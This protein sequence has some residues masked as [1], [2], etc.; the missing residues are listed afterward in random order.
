MTNYKPSMGKF[1]AYLK[2]ILKSPPRIVVKAVLRRLE[3]AANRI[4]ERAKD[5][6]F[7]SYTGT[8]PQGELFRY[9][10][11][12]PALLRESD[13]EWVR[14]LTDRYL[15]HRF[16]LLGSGWVSVSHGASCRGVEGNR[17][18]ESE[19]VKA[20]PEGRWLKTK[21]NKADRIESARRWRTV[22]ED[23]SPIDWHLDFKSGYRW[24][25]DIWYQ[26]VPYAHEPGVDIKV[27]WEL[28]RMQHLPQLAWAY[29]FAAEG[30][31]GF[32]DADVY[33][34]QFR[35]QV[36]DFT[37]TNPPRFGVNWRC[38]MDVGIRVANQLLAYDLFQAFGAAFDADFK[39]VFR[40]SVYEHGL[41]IIGNLEW[42]EQ[43]RGNHYLADIV[44]LLFVA[45]YLPRTEETD[46][47]LAFAVQELVKEA[48]SQFNE[49]GSNFEGST[50]Y[51]RLSSEMMIF[52]AAL[53]LGLP[54]E[55]Y[56]A[57]KHCNH[58][59]LRVRP[60][61]NAGPTPLYPIPGSDRPA[62]FP[63]RYFE[64]LEK[65]AEFTMDITRPDGNIPQVGDNDAGRFFKLAPDIR[66]VTAEKTVSGYK[67]PPD[68]FAP[69]ETEEYPIENLNDHRRMVGAVNGLFERPDF[70][71]FAG[72]RCIDGKVAAMLSRNARVSSYKRNRTA[73]SK[74][75]DE[76]S[77]ANTQPSLKLSAYPEFGLYVYHSGRFYWAVRCGP[78]GQRGNGGHSH[79]DQLSFELAV[80]DEPVFIDPGT[81]LYTPVPN[82]RNRFRSTAMH[83]TLAIPGIEQNPWNPGTY[84]LF[85][86][87]ADNTK[88]EAK[89]VRPN[90]FCGE[91]HGY[92]VTHRRTMEYKEGS[93]FVTDELDDERDAKLFFHLAPGLKA[94]VSDENRSVMIK[95]EDTLVLLSADTGSWET[96]RNDYSPSYGR[97]EP[98]VTVALKW[99]GRKAAW[100]VR[101]T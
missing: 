49:D 98:N 77:N 72:S 15:A 28:A 69:S 88:A 66:F 94:E 40:R 6:F 11:N 30:R 46:A 91:H 87:I 4:R 7:T 89:T 61:L 76:D 99:S 50:S 53:A 74:A 27:P 33:R 92:G 96:F 21:I 8:R 25:E 9:I 64:Q 95:K 20:D 36:L 37:A 86:V 81:Y 12:D 24:K 71:E 19:T 70:T 56:A 57:L 43:L 54:P 13:A 73:P 59:R 44:G 75:A 29:A 34:K 84:G 48:D 100:T 101:M 68:D 5:R 16:D 55:K 39:D 62:P 90:V 47:W 10:Q 18:P 51:H 58:R 80:D 60:K 1:R 93:I 41:H 45:A 52:G 82:Q 32:A 42:S 85:S 31:D 22:D 79:N 65:A 2:F 14:S 26:E 97:I 38:T 17:Y 83:N 3:N 63:A 23:Y 35:N 78:V 67:N